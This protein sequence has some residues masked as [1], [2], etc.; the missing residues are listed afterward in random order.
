MCSFPHFQ[1]IGIKVSYNQRPVCVKVIQ[2]EPFVFDGWI[3]QQSAYTIAN[4]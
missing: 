3:K 2:R 4:S 1:Q